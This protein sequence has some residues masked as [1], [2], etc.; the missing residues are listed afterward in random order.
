MF[1][2]AYVYIQI[3]KACQNFHT[4]FQTIVLPKT[5]TLSRVE[6]NFKGLPRLV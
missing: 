3:N 5:V 1:K 6:E 2:E 4:A